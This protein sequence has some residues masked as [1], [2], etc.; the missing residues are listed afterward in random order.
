MPA[1]DHFDALP[2][3]RSLLTDVG[4]RPTYLT[5]SE[6]AESGEAARALAPVSWHYRPGEGL[7]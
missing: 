7:A 6:L 5:T 2:A 3:F 1:L 4:A